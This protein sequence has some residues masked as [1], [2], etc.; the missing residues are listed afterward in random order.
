MSPNLLW[1]LPELLLAAGIHVEAEVPD[2]PVS[3]VTDDSR[4][5]R[6]GA[7]FVAVKGVCHDGHLFIRQALERGAQSVLLEEMEEISLPVGVAA[8][9]VKAT[10]SL[11]GPLIHAFL[12]FPTHSLRMLAVTGTNGKTTVAYLIQ[13][14]LEQSGIPCGL[15]GTI[16]YRL[17]S[18]TTPSS[19]TTPGAVNLNTLFSQML[20]KD[21]QACAMEVSSHALD[22]HRT[23]GIRFQ[24]AVFTNLSPEHLDYHRTLEEYLR[25]KCRLFES[26]EP[27]A[28]ALINRDDPAWE[29]V[30]ASTRAKVLT[31][32]IHHAADLTAKEIRSSLEGTTC[33]IV[34]PEGSF[35]FHWG[36]IGSY[37]VENVLAAVGV[38][39]NCGIPVPKALLALES[40]P[41]VPGRLERIQMGQPFPVFVDYAHTDH[42]LRQV[43]QVLRDA[44]HRR[45]VV[46]FGCGGDRDQTKRPRMGRV[47]AEWADQVIMTSDN[48]RS[49]NPAG[50]AKQI[51]QGLKEMPTPWQI[52]LDRKKAIQTALGLADSNSLVLI[53]G[54]GHETGQVFRDRTIPFD[55]RAVV[56]EILSDLSFS[57]G[58]KGNR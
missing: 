57:M 32:G 29:R 56:R 51:A 34:T 4:Q 5:V 19:N 52:V 21:L 11:I 49:E 3:Q 40:F 24:C 22:Q 47:A 9:R 38:G 12:G 58:L 25:A 10:R 48:P 18:E 50:I 39:M 28:T 31:Y 30:L 46:V 53:A 2:L 23:D 44:S 20:A 42:A 1:R 43:L 15:I 14:F 17:G 13:H 36:L 54:K 8:L 55:D 6:P 45:I 7:L 33:R 35:D 37:N 27:A 41:G 16:C 26:L